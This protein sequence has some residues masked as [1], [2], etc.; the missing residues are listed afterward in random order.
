MGVGR[1]EEGRGKREEGEG[2]REKGEGRREE[3][4]GN[5]EWGVVFERFLLSVNS[6]CPILFCSV[7]YVVLCIK[8]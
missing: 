2:R 8:T 1:M 6:R 3:G 7:R 5:G 4:L